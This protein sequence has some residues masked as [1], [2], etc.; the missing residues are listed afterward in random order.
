MR[1]AAIGP[2]AGCAS[3]VVNA[4]AQLHRD[5]FPVWGEAPLSRSLYIGF[6][7]LAR[8]PGARVKWGAHFTPDSKTPLYHAAKFDVIIG[9]IAVFL[10]KLADIIFV[11]G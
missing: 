6:L 9:P 3:M 10:V 2:I 7:L 5:L 11:H 4:E 1:E 8:K